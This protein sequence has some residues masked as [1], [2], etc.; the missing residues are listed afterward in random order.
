MR[1]VAATIAVA[2]LLA[3]AAITSTVASQEERRSLAECTMLLP[4]GELFNFELVGTVDTRG[5]APKMRGEFSMSDG[6]TRDRTKD[7]EAFRACFLKLV[8]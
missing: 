2:G 6:P 3:G 4:K 8:R 7:A 1:L 5:D